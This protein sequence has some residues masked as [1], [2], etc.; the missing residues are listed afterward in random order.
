MIEKSGQTP[1]YQKT[2]SIT[3]IASAQEAFSVLY[4]NFHVAHS[5]GKHHLW[6]QIEPHE[7]TFA[8]LLMG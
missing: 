1:H 3:L 4:A 7:A 8:A 6:S 2:P 5:L